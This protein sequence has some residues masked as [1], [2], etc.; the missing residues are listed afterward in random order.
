MTHNLLAGGIAITVAA[1]ITIALNHHMAKSVK[2]MNA[3]EASPCIRGSGDCPACGKPLAVRN[4][5][6]NLRHRWEDL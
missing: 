5:C 6:E 1:I 4:L 2:A 3:R